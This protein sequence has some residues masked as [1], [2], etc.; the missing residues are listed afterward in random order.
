MKLTK[1]SSA[2]STSTFPRRE[3]AS[4]RVV[5]L[6]LVV[7]ALGLGGGAFFYSRSMRPAKVD[8]LPALSAATVTTLKSLEAPV[9]LRFYSLLPS[10]SDAALQPF[11]DR[12]EQLL[13]AYKRDAGGKLTFN[14]QTAVSDETAKAA[15]KDGV[16]AFNLE[17]GDACYLGIAISQ[18]KQR[19][20]LAQIS[21]DWEA[22]LESDLTRAIARVQSAQPPVVVTT[23][24][25][26]TAA[27]ADEAVK[28]LIPNPAAVALEDGARQI[29]E[30][31]LKEFRDAMTSLEGRIKEAEDKIVQAQQ[32][33][34]QPELQAARKLLQEAQAERAAKLQQV[35]EEA[36]ARVAAWERLKKSTTAPAANPQQ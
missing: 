14:R 33:G 9:E 28:S 1:T 25:R 29:R 23:E 4:A 13:A 31:S 22:A 27:A 16:K 30:V 20:A 3:F 21:P 8:G 35:G 17:K 36:M 2:N 6:V 10:G 26:K 19:E 32:S 7:F 15:G 11:A 24:A 5:L 34:A 12:V 18:G